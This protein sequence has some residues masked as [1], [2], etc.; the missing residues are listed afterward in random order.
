MAQARPDHSTPV[1]RSQTARAPKARKLGLRRDGGAMGAFAALLAKADIRIGG[2]RPWDMAIHHPRTAERILARGSIGLGESYM[3]G[4]WDSPRLDE[5]VHRILAAELD[6]KV[7]SAA[8]MAQGLRARLF[9]LQNLRRAW[10]VG[11]IHYDT[12]NE[13]FAAMLDSRMAYTCGY[14]AQ[15]H[16]LEEA[17]TAKLDLVCRKLGLAPGMR[18]LDIGC[19][20]GSLMQFAA[21]RYGVSCVGLTISREQAEYGQARC[22]GL[23]VEF[24]L[25]DYRDADGHEHFDR[26]ASI[27][28]FEH[29]GHKNHGGYFAM[30]R[31]C[32]AD[33]GLFLLHTIGKNLRHTPTDP[34]IDRYIFPNGDLPALGQIADAAE[35]RFVIE[36]VH[37]F[38]ADYDRTLMAWHAN[39][40]AAWPHFAKRYGERFRRM[41]SYY[42]RACA[43][44]F[45]ART[46][47]L[48]QIVLSP[49]G[50]P[51]GYRRPNEH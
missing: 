15:A 51:G 11:E 32:L 30:A 35:D 47:Q 33:D 4:W 44:T 27:G 13:F 45:R 28:M 49:S 43:G 20:W 42:L 38:G 14:W 5:F 6:K 40:E 48:W 3:D 2:G 46:T 16:T 34:W 21:E 12:G 39:F 17:Q 37:N 50:V 36:D 26:I 23:P 41:W 18:L 22:A 8:M 10:R 9:N 29:V 24:R 31:R 25:M 7:G 1:D 19:G